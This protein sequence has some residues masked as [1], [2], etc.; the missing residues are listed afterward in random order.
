VRSLVQP[1]PQLSF[2]DEA[3]LA[4]PVVQAFLA[5]IPE[6]RRLHAAR[7]LTEEES[8]RT[9]RDLPRHAGLDR[10][11]HG[12]P[13]LRKEWWVELAFTGRNF[14]LGRL[15]FEVRD[16]RLQIH[17]PE[18]G[19][20]LTPAAVDASLARACE[21]FPEHPEALCKSWL[22]DPQLPGLLPSG[23]N[24][25]DFQQRF[26]LTGESDPGDADVLEFVFHTLGRDL[27][28]L[29]RDTALERSLGDHLRSGGHLHAV[30]GTLAL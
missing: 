24:I 17:I 9:L 26:E 6:A 7:G 18:E 27:D 16:D 2:D 11:L 1:P 25:V 8:W 20:P 22:L 28:R 19:G 15:Q 10:L 23:S 29:S 4:D 5:R 21:L 12:T 14:E 13:G 3:D 30:A